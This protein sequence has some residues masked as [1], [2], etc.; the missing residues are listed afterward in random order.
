MRKFIEWRD[1]FE[2]VFF[3]VNIIG[4]DDLSGELHA[5]FKARGQKYVATV[6]EE[7]IDQI[8]KRMPAFIIA[9]VEDGDYLVEL[10]GASLSL[11]SRVQVTDEDIQRTSDGNH[12]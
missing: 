2:L 1:T 10:P 11:G 6:K 12:R 3:N 8:G 4:R 7:R 9:D 5:E